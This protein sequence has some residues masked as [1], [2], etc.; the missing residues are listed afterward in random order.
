MG[1]LRA[2]LLVVAMLVG[3]A[4]SAADGIAIDN[5]TARPT[6]VSNG[7]SA[8]YFVI[9]NSS[10]APDRLL[11]AKSPL[12][13]ITEVHTIIREGEVMKMRA[14]GPVEIKAGETLAFAPGGL[15]V[16]LVGVKDK[17]EVGARVPITLVF[18]K[19]G[20][21]TFEAVVTK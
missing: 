1:S 3:R 7:V 5:A 15:H 10:S 11:A 21:R 9:R 19:A 6:F 2:A 8:A 20:E 4:S 13:N 17:L 18:E 12:A 16:M 14:A